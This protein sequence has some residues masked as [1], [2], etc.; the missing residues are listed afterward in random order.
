VWTPQPRGTQLQLRCSVVGLLRARLAPRL[1]GSRGSAP[2]AFPALSPT[3]FG[4]LVVTK[5][6]ASGSF[7]ALR[8]PGGEEMIVP[9]S[10]GFAGFRFGS[11]SSLLLPSRASRSVILVAPTGCDRGMV[12]CLSPYPRSHTGSWTPC[13][14]S[15][16]EPHVADSDCLSTVVCCCYVIHHLIYYFIS[17]YVGRFAV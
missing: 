16:G 10:G 1:S 9:F 15:L 2:C 17:M 4:L 11:K 12:A 13:V 3:R 5:P 14:F 6:H 8:V 7:G